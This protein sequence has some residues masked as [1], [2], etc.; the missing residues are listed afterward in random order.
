[1]KKLIGLLF[2]I[3]GITVLSSVLIGQSSFAFGDKRTKSETFAE[4]EIHNIKLNIKS[5]DV[6]FIAKD[7]QDI[8]VIIEDKRAF[9]KSISL[10]QV[11]DVLNI[12]QKGATFNMF[13]STQVTIEVPSSYERDVN[14]ASSSGNIVIKNNGEK[15]LKLDRLT[16]QATSGDTQF[17]DVD[18]KQLHIEKSSGNVKGE[19]LSTE[20]T[21]A[22]LTSGNLTLNGFEGEIDAKATSGDISIVMDEVKGNGNVKATSGDINVKLPHKSNTHLKAHVS[23]GDIN[24]DQRFKVKT[25]MEED[26][27]AKEGNGKYAFNIKATSG[28]IDIQ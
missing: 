24:V 13:Q 21:F 9:K 10:N 12:K 26:L 18:A 11:G 22:H 17:F 2:V 25:Q 14:V 28:D 23:S 8:K 7:R 5:A 4:D 15:P 6:N 27:E 20:T 1:M 16:V 3:I 19:N